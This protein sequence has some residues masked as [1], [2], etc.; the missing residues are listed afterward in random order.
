MD[1]S[2]IVILGAEKVGKSAIAQ[3]FVSRTFPAKHRKTKED[4][5]T[6][7]ANLPGGCQLSVDLVD[8]S[9]TEKR[10][11]MREYRTQHADG[12]VVVYAVDDAKSFAR[13]LKICLRIEMIRGS[14]RP[15]IVLVGNKSDSNR[16]VP[17]H[18]ASKVATDTLH[19]SHVECS[20]M[21]IEDVDHIFGTLL[22]AM[23]SRRKQRLD[24]TGSEC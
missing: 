19:C 23:N 15:P 16:V 13:A 4:Y 2:N 8:T 14:D 24:S 21:N 17:T 7:T 9:G 11:R 10:Q 22:M 5:Y 20:A 1:E 3:Q 12:Y 18:T 6:T